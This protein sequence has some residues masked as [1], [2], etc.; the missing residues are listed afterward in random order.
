MATLAQIPDIYDAR[1][2]S[3]CVHI[4]TEFQK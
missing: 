4:Y 1:S 2:V 3:S